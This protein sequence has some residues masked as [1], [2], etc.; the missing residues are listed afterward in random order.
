ML[1]ELGSIEPCPATDVL[2]DLD[3]EPDLERGASA[4]RTVVGDVFTGLSL[5]S[6]RAF[7][8]DT[9]TTG[10]LGNSPI[11]CTGGMAAG[12]VVKSTRLK[13]ELWELSEWSTFLRSKNYTYPQE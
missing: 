2:V 9:E 4:F 13:T 12:R 3:E 5:S 1:I 10:M 7:N 8:P 6:F 11:G